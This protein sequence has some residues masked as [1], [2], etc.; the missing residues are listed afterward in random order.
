MKR[1]I[2]AYQFLND[3]LYYWQRGHNLRDAINMAHRVLRE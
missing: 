2:A 1:M 3:A